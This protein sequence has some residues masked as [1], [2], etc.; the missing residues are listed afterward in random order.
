[1]QTLK[2]LTQTQLSIIEFSNF[3]RG[4]R[5]SI[6]M[7]LG[8]IPFALVLGAQATNK[9]FSLIEVP[10]FTGLNFAGGSEFAILEIWTNPPNI[11][12]LMFIT[13]T[14]ALTDSKKY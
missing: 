5:T 3:K 2:N 7:L 4:I 6:P 10:L 12:M 9:G 14:Y 11:L 13:R 1:M 8:I